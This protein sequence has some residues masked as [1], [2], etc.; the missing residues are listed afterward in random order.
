MQTIF[1]RV[2]TGVGCNID[3]YRLVDCQTTHTCCKYQMHSTPSSLNTV[4]QFHI[5]SSTSLVS[6]T[7][8]FCLVPLKK[9]PPPLGIQH[10]FIV[11]IIAET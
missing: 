3:S 2:A 10:D 9:V 11:S 5:P 4:S 6:S 1:A 7:L 8:E